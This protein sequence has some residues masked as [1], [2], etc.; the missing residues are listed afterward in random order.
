[1]FDEEEMTSEHKGNTAM[2]NG[3]AKKHE[4]RSDT[5]SKPHIRGDM[6]LLGNIR[7][8]IALEG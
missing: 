2:N 6:L 5:G 7:L 8:S 4:P 3:T 1:M